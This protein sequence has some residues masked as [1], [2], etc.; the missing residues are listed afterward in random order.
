MFSLERFTAL[1]ASS[2]S[3]PDREEFPHVR[4]GK[5]NSFFL[6]VV[7]IT[8]CMWRYVYV[9]VGVMYYIMREINLVI[10]YDSPNR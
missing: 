2:I 6:E 4:S 9:R 10:F 7:V 8:S 3:F 1:F 5:N